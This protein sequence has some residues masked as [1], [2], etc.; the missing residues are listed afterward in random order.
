MHRETIE[1]WVGE[2]LT[3]TRAREHEGLLQEYAPQVLAAFLEAA[4]AP[5]QVAPGDLEEGDLKPGLLDGVARLEIPA[6]LRERIPPLCASFLEEMQDQ[7]RLSG[8]ARLATVV[9]ILAAPYL[10]AASGKGTSYVAPA[11][12]VGRNDPCPCGSGRKYK[13]CCMRR[14]E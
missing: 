11:E 9:R 2:F 3:S 1:H 6:S 8:G 13:Q 12:K 4:C 10:R 5:R 7:G 14:L